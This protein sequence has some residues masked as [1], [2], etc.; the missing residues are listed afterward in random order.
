MSS[1]A[2]D[3]R[4]SSNEPLIKQAWETDYAEYI[5]QDPRAV[6][7][8]GHC[9]PWADGTRTA[10]QLAEHARRYAERWRP[11]ADREKVILIIPALGSGKHA[12]YRELVPVDGI[13]ADLVVNQLVDHYRTL[14]PMG[15]HSGFFMYGHSAGAQFAC[16]YALA[17]PDRLRGL[18][19]SAPGRYAFPDPAVS[20]PYGMGSTTEKNPPH[21]QLAIPFP[22]AWTKVACGL[23]TNIVVGSR[24]TSLQAE[25]PGHPRRSRLDHAIQWKTA[26]N[27]LAAASTCPRRVELTLV[28]GAS[29]DPAG[30]LTVSQR[31]LS[32][33]MR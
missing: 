22:S 16:R 26:M 28:P 15:A 2:R 1:P 5:P 29:H 10:R 33:Q 14:L 7:V 31:V 19:L 32:A 3:R 11:F 13:R 21:P 23:P 20:W 17:H 18:V 27:D 6:L 4:S 12:G 9:Y 25:A 8:I 30:L 24:D